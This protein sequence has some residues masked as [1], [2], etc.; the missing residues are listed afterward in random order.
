MNKKT[1]VWIFVLFSLISLGF[2]TNYDYWI[3]H[4][5][6]GNP[7]NY[8]WVKVDNIPASSTKTIYAIKE[9]GFSPNGDAVFEFFDDFE[10]TS[11][12]TSKWDI[13]E[14]TLSQYSVSNSVLSATAKGSEVDKRLLLFSK[15]TYGPGNILESRASL[16][17][18]GSKLYDGVGFQ[19]RLLSVQGYPEFDD[20][21]SWEN[22][23]D[24]DAYL[25]TITQN[26]LEYAENTFSL[27]QAYRIY[28]IFWESYSKVMF[29]YDSTLAATHTTNIPQH[30]QYIVLLAGSHPEHSSSDIRTAYFDWVR[31][32]KYTATE[33]SVTVTDMGTYYKI[34]ITNNEASELTGYQVAIPIND[35][36]VSSTTESIKFTDTLPTGETVT[37]SIN[38]TSGYVGDSVTVNCSA[39]DLDPNKCYAISKSG[40]NCLIEFQDPEILTPFTSKT[41]YNESNNYTIT[42]SCKHQNLTFSCSIVLMDDSQ[43]CNEL[44]TIDSILATDSATVEVL[45]TPPTEPDLSLNYIDIVGGN[46]VQATCENSTDTVD[47]DTITYRLIVTNGTD[48]LHNSTTNFTYITSKS[49][50]NQTLTFTCVADDGYDT[51]ETSQ[52]EFVYGVDF[53]FD[54]EKSLGSYTTSYQTSA[55]VIPNQIKVNYTYDGTEYVYCDSNCNSSGSVTITDLGNHDFEWK[56]FVE[57][58]NYTA[59]DNFW[60][61]A[62]L[63]N[64]T[65]KDEKDLSL[66]DTANVSFVTDDYGYRF[67][68]SSSNSELGFVTYG[69]GFLLIQKNGYFSE[70]IPMV[71]TNQT[72]DIIAYILKTTDGTTMQVQLKDSLSQPLAGKF[73]D[74]YKYYSSENAYIRVT[75]K[76]TDSQGYALVTLET[77]SF[78]KYYA[79]IS[80]NDT[81]QLAYPYPFQPTANSMTLYYGSFSLPAITFGTLANLEYNISTSRTGS[82]ETVVSFFFNDKTG[83]VTQGCVEAYDRRITRDVFLDSN[84][85]NAS[86]GT[87]FVTIPDANW[88]RTLYY[89]AKIYI[90]ATNQW[91]VVKTGYVRKETD[92]IFGSTSL[93]VIML[94]SI[95]AVAIGSVMSPIVGFIMLAIVMFTTSLF[96]VTIMASSTIIS[97]IVVVLFILFKKK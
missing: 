28:R 43:G 92:R 18:D 69:D 51:N 24:G 59:S 85:V 87:V 80:I 29:Y 74:L 12:N 97:F 66:I 95:S 77:D 88:S 96:G 56:I 27:P 49:Q 79:R 47:G 42:Q 84:C 34:D 65:I 72:G 55:Q 13:K 9:S 57:T 50:I 4:D 6:S 52:N 32:R 19:V 26:D 30:T 40:P 14:N 48:T 53:S 38:Q 2:A 33:P 22:P 36:D 37:I 70:T 76:I 8:V 16:F 86:S 68:Y 83:F 58:E 39:T 31:V 25:H 23:T 35:L 45:N 78:Y 5:E 91:H 81:P 46:I 93:F 7:Q 82:N 17:G 89:K 62:A 15:N 54:N 20:A 64:L 10:G 67:N 73:V 61:F 41:S 94:I 75:T 11:L 60:V 3:E 21:I 1:L 44:A 63:I 71:T 90:K